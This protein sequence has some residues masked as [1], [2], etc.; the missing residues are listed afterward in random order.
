MP[1]EAEDDRTPD[2]DAD[3]P[4]PSAPEG[5]EAAVDQLAAADRRA[6]RWSWTAGAVPTIALF[7]WLLMAG[8][9][10]PLQ[11]Q[12]FDDFYD[13]Q[14]RALFDGRWNVPT[15]SVGFEGFV[16]DG[17]TYIY[18][19]PFPALLR[20][21]ILL[22]TDRFDG[23]LTTISMVLAMVV[24]AVAAHRLNLAVR[25][26]VR[27]VAPVGRVERIATAGMAVAV[28]GGVPLWLAS[29]AA[30][31]HEAILWGLALTV[32][33]LASVLGWLRRPTARGLAAATFLTTAA[34]TS[35][36][37]M[38]LGLL[39]G[40][41]FVGVIIAASR[42]ASRR[43]GRPPTVLPRARLGGVVV[44]FVVAAL[45]VAIP[46][47]QKFGNPVSPPIDSH[48]ATGLPERQRFLEANDGSYFGT[49][50]VPTTLLQYAR[51]DALDLRGDFPWVDFPAE[52]PTV[53]GDTVFDRV[54]WA[55][56]V[57]VT[58][59]VLVLLA[60][61]G[62]VWLVAGIRRRDDRVGLLALWGGTWAAAAGAL[63][64]G[65][66][67]HRYIGD[68]APIVIVPALCGVHVVAGRAAGW[69]PGLR[70]GVGAGLAVLVLAGVWINVGLGVQYQ[71]ER[72]FN[73]P[74]EWRTEL[75]GWRADLP[76]TRRTVVE[77][78]PTDRRLPRASDG[79]LAVV[80]DCLGLYQRVGE[81]WYGVDRGPGVGVYDIRVDLYALGDLA[82]GE[83][84]P[85]VTFGDGP[86]ASVVG[87]V[88]LPDG[89]V[90]ADLD[91]PTTDGW[92]A[93]WA[94]DLEGEVTVRVVTD[95]RTKD[96]FLRVGRYHLNLAPSSDPTA[97][98]TV[99]GLP[100]GLSVPG[101]V[102]R[103][104]GEVRALPFDDSLCRDATG[105]G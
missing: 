63:T 6:L 66:I 79:T 55:S 41:G 49:N 69:R 80:G 25:H 78:S 51:P 57:P 67:G 28:L 72:G 23:R 43:S 85:L 47:I 68:M 14:A 7:T 84:A 60:I 101:V 2:P 17:R 103:Y 20:M 35:R 88:R 48:L 89:R 21:P 10:A 70:R 93:G 82:P 40:L 46:N 96:S 4:G 104:P 94:R 98:P 29:M 100:D 18:F 54:E 12:F 71:R 64:I 45:A 87:L 15:G 30:V 65:Y 81:T 27:G 36:Q 32:A 8:A 90:R 52:G 5:S 39:M 86:D 95:P 76:G 53:V 1:I 58:M 9:W 74:E 59:P 33:A 61:P 26:L 22:V 75:A 91:T 31:F 83:R 92:R 50:F 19:G 3:V 13:H 11:R 99:G 105:V 34:A 44:I 38:G 42:L 16:M 73:I 97:V 102:D 37:P 24:L 62:V 56:S 77:V